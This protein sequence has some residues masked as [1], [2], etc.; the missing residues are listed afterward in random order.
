MKFNNYNLKPLF[1]KGVIDHKVAEIAK[2]I[3]AQFEN[4]DPIFIGV[5]NGSFIFLAD[6]LRKITIDC[7]M[8]FIKL[9]SY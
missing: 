6:L 5:L 4:K 1:S 9:H 3:S 2:K 7:E 8:D